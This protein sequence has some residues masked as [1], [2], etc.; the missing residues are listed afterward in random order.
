MFF[1]FFFHLDIQPRGAQIG[2]LTRLLLRLSLN[3]AV[4]LLV[5]LKKAIKYSLL[6]LIYIRGAT[7]LKGLNFIAFHSFFGKLNFC[8][9]FLF[10]FTNYM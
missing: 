4:F 1:L 6:T 2:R 9:R 8:T 7:N 10:M 3:S 5:P